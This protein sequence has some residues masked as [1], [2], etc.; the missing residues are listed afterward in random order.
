MKIQSGRLDEWIGEKG[1]LKSF[2]ILLH[3]GGGGFKPS[4]FMKSGV[5][6]EGRNAKGRMLFGMERWRCERGQSFKND[7]ESCRW[8][9][10]DDFKSSV[11]SKEN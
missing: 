11:K 2:K 4:P 6:E 5:E 10:K 8:E 1:G 9:K 3:E 7:L